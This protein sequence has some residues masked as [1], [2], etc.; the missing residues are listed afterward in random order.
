MHFYRDKWTVQ[1]VISSKHRD[2]ALRGCHKDIGHVR[3]NGYLDLLRDT[4]YW[5]TMPKDKENY[6]RHVPDVCISTR[7]HKN[8]TQSI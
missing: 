3:V 1:I 8:R 2:Q 5:P 7:N 4:F 6:V